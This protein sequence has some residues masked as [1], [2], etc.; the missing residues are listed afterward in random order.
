MPKPNPI[1]IRRRET[2]DVNKGRIPQLDLRITD[3]FTKATEPANNTERTQI[4]HAPVRVHV[5]A[6]IPSPRP[7]RQRERRSQAHTGRKRKAY[8]EK[9]RLETAAVRRAKACAFCREKK[10]KCRDTV[11][12]SEI[13]AISQRVETTTLRQPVSISD[14]YQETTTYAPLPQSRQSWIPSI[15]QYVNQ[16]VSSAPVPPL[17]GHQAS[18][19]SQHHVATVA[20]ENT[21]RH[22]PL[23]SPTNRH[24]DS[25]N[26]DIHRPVSGLFEAGDN[27]LGEEIGQISSEHR[28]TPLPWT[29]QTVSASHPRGSPSAAYS[30]VDHTGSQF[31]PT[32]G[33]P[34]SDTQ[35]LSQQPTPYGDQDTW[36]GEQPRS[37]YEQPPL[38][39]S[40]SQ[41]LSEHLFEFAPSRHNDS[42]STADPEYSFELSDGVDPR[43]DYT[44]NA[45]N[46]DHFQSDMVSHNQDSSVDYT[47]VSASGPSLDYS[48]TYSDRASQAHSKGL[49]YAW[50]GEGC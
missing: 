41:A 25:F 46:L 11:P 32:F 39:Y 40:Y 33:L 30:S 24:I 17:E 45:L 5:P 42:Q 18:W 27:L 28:S 14:I 9:G 7:G 36:A 22:F 35:D 23:R 3:S 50:N 49:Y 20:L 38:S 37:R 44:Q 10:I 47:D 26:D 21:N 48:T 16:P 34:S 29:W 1:P 8:S 12:P 13:A 43:Y 6:A 2:S 19:S 4:S 31:E 15:E